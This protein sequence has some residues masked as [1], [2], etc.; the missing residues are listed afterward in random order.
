MQIFDFRKNFIV[1]FISKE[2]DIINCIMNIS[3]NC[4]TILNILIE[5]DKESY[6]IDLPFTTNQINKFLTFIIFNKIGNIDESDI[7]DILIIADYLEYN[8]K[9]KFSHIFYI[10]ILKNFTSNYYKE[11]FFERIKKEESFYWITRRNKNL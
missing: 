5:Y 9:E 1:R 7:L 3:I 10:K 8:N 2:R 4:K 6:D 11:K